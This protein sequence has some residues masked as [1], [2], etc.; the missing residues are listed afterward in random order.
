MILKNTDA[1][2]SLLS[3]VSTRGASD[4]ARYVAEEFA[5]GR[6]QL[7]NSYSLGLISKG[8]FDELCSIA[9]EC[10]SANWDGY[11]AEPVA[12]ETYQWAYRFLEALPL[13]SPAPTIGAEPDGHITIEWY[14]APQRTLSVSISPEGD[15]YYAALIGVSK[16]YGTEP[17]FGDVPAVIL[18]LLGRVTAA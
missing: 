5:K 18:D 11:E 12:Q 3:G 15:L 7:Q 14:R 1:V 13:G 2:A 9:E 8:V 16:A 10:S 4:A 17:F 6:H